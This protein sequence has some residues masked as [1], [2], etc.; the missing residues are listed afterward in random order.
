MHVFFKKGCTSVFDN[1]EY[2]G[3]KAQMKQG[4]NF[5]VEGA[6]QLLLKKDTF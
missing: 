2:E 4:L 1:R 6:Q 5:G 3:T